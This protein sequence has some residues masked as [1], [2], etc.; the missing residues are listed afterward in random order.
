MGVEEIAPPHNLQLSNLLL[1]W[2]VSFYPHPS[3]PPKS[4]EGMVQGVAAKWFVR[5]KWANP[6]S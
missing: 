4:G 1:L 3:P 5:A 6:T 2:F